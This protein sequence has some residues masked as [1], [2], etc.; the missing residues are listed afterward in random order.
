MET[1]DI[2]L[3][4]AR[5]DPDREVREQA[6]FWLSQVGTDRAVG[7]LDSILRTS[8]DPSIQEKAVFA[9]SQHDGARAPSRRCAAI[10]ERP[11]LSERPAG[12]GDLLD[13]PERRAR[14]TTAFLRA[15]YG[16]LKEE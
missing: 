9:L 3:Q 10:A 16:R 2:L 13:R 11:D 7:A 14:R 6:V 5:T 4:T 1:E 15:L 12:E 8:K